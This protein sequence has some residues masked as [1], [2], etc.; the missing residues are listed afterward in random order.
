[1]K[2]SIKTDCKDLDQEGLVTF[3]E[4]LEQPAFRGRQIMSWLYRSGITGFEQMT[5]LSKSFRALLS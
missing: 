3:V 1:M 4:S 5:D 2:D